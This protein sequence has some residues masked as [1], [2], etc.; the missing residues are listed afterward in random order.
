MQMD[1]LISRDS[2]HM[3]DLIRCNGIW[4]TQTDR[5]GIEY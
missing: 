3:P 4:I 2:L 5:L 1:V